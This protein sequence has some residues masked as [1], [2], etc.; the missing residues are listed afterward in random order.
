MP[1]HAFITVELKIE[2]NRDLGK[3]CAVEVAKTKL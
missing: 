2:E 1:C 3:V